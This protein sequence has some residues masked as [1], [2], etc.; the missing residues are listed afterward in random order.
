MNRATFIEKLT[1][2]RRTEKLERSRRDADTK[3]VYMKQIEA[4]VRESESKAFR[5]AIEDTVGD[6]VSVIAS[7]CAIP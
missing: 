2:V 3:S 5:L 7:D 6:A 4:L 1:E